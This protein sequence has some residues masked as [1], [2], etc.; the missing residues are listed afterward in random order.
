MWHKTIIQRLEHNRNIF[1]A[2]LRNISSEQARW[3]YSPEKWSILE[4]VNHLLDEE[5]GDF[6]QR[7]QFAL[8]N[9][10]EP[11]RRIRP[12]EWVSEKDYNKKDFQSSLDELL[13]E[14]EKSIR[15]LN[16]LSSPDWSAEDN[17]PYGKTMTAEEILVNWLAHDFLHL[18]QIVR[19]N[20]QYLSNLVPSIDLGYAGDW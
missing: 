8:L 4:V 18:R 1:E 2:S 9:P 14:R 15:W 7:L 5:N 6:R 16:T 17:Y 20:W 11:W 12:E 13:V 19:L 3:K 10:D